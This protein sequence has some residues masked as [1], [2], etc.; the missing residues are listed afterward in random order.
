[1]ER[2][3]SMSQALR[4]GFNTVIEHFAFF[5]AFILVYVTCASFGT[6]FIMGLFAAPFLKKALAVLSVIDATGLDRSEVMPTLIKHL[7]SEFSIAFMIGL[8]CATLFNRFLKL[9]FT[10]VSLDMYE[11]ET[12]SLS[13]LFSCARLIFHDAIAASL[14]WM[15]C[16]LGLMFFFFP[17]IYLALRYGFFHQIIVDKQVSALESLHMSAQI[18]HG[19]KWELFAFWFLLALINMAG[20]SF[21][22][23]GVLVTIPMSSLMYVYVY[24]KLLQS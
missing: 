23:I 6:T 15:M 13:R 17:G 12:S 24:K 16:V 5:L 2:R 4:F 22:G 3:F 7:G 9:G 19:I 21:F 20:F 8:L 1:M 18:T 11:K 10:R 14:Y